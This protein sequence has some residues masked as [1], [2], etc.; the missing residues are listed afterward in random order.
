MPNNPAPLLP[1]P[2][3]QQTKEIAAAIRQAELAPLIGAGMSIPRGLPHWKAL[4]DRL[5]L[6][7]KQWDRSQTSR[8]LSPEHYIA[9]IRQNFQSDLAIVSY[10]RRRIAEDGRVSFGQLLFSALYTTPK[11][12]TPE[13]SN[14]HRHLVTLF[15]PY[16]RRIW[17][18]NYDDLLEE[19]AR[20]INIPASTLDPSR[21]QA[22]SELMVAH[23]HG[24]L[25]P[26]GRA[27]G[28]PEPSQAETILALA[29]DDYH[30]IA[31]DVIG[32]TNRE[33]YRLFDEH[34]V[35]ILGMSLDDPNVRRVLATNLR[36]PRDQTA[37]HFALMTTIAL[38]EKDLPG[39][40]KRTRHV[41]ADDANAFRSWYWRQYGVEI[42]RLPDY[43][44]ILPFLVR[45]RYE[46]F[47]AQ[48]GDLWARGAALGYQ[49]IN[50]WQPAQQR[51]AK[52]YLDEAFESLHRDF[53]VPASELVEIGVFLLKPDC[54]TLEL[55]FRGGSEI[56]AQPGKAEFSADPDHPTG[57]AGRVFVSGDGVIVSRDH[58]LH[59]FGLQPGERQSSS[60]YQ[61]IISV[62]LIDWSQGGIPLGVAYVTTART[63]GALFK[64]PPTTRNQ[65]EKSLEDLYQWMHLSIMELIEILRKLGEK[66]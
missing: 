46:S 39:V 51:V 31:S 40:H 63:D 55:T 43:D 25:G 65:G 54:K 59:N 15:A 60:S 6:A 52:L 56:L 57:V 22:K 16:P 42:V 66:Q 34:R 50:P 3:V 21:R 45:L 9:L 18:T 64:L 19:A 12:F 47:G 33:F 35:L 24:F 58:P 1:E 13:P 5:I 30:T 26:P 49:A 48:P 53:G 11:L 23:L 62:P 44:T 32:W 28:H 8:L 17:T 37:R 36:H 14:I 27:E 20:S 61:G 38:D 41:C 7:W 4:V 29:E 2:V 10:L